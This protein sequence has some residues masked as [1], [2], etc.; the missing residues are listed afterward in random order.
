MIS[1]QAKKEIDIWV[2][3]Y[4]QGNLSTALMQTLPIVQKE[5]GRS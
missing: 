1:D 5:N 4:P 3:K 2:A